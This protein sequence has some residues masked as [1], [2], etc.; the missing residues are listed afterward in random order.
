[1]SVHTQIDVAT[2]TTIIVLITLTTIQRW[3]MSRSR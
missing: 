1:M 2:M 3:W